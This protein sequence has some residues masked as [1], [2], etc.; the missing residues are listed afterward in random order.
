MLRINSTLIIALIGLI[1]FSSCE[2][3]SNKSKIAE[4]KK[5]NKSLK[6]FELLNSDSTGVKFANTIS[7]DQELVF[8]DFQYQFN[9]GGVAIADFDNDGL[10]DI[11]FTGNEV[12]NKL[13]KNLGGLKFE[14]VTAK[15]GT[16]QSG[17]WCNGVAI[18]D[19]NRDGLMDIYISQGGWL[20][21]TKR[22]NSLFI[23][24]G[25]F[26]FTESAQNFGIADTGYTTQSAFF[27]M[28]LDGDLDLY[29]MNHDNVWSSNSELSKEKYTVRQVTEDRIY[30]NDNGKFIDITLESGLDKEVAG[31]YGLGISVGDINNDNYPDIYISNDYDSPDRLYVNQKDGTFKN[32]TKERTTHIALYSMGNDIADIN[33]DGHLDI[34][35]LDMSAE[36][37]V[38][39]KTQ[40]GA[41][42]P[43]KFYELVRFGFPHQYMYNT[44]QLNNGNGTFSDIA[45]LAGISSTD[46]SWAPISADFDNDGH[47]DIFVSNGY[48]L[49]D[50]DND[51]NN[52]TNQLYGSRK[53]LTKEERRIVFDGTPSTPLANYMYKNNGD[54]TFSKKTYEWNLGEKTFSMGSAFADLDNDGDLDLILNNIEAEAFIYKNNARDKNGNNYL[55]I[56]VDEKSINGEQ[57]K[58][59]LT[60][61]K[62]QQTQ[63]LNPVRGYISSVERTLHFGIGTLD[64]VDKVEIYWNNGKYTVLNNPEINKTHV[65]SNAKSTVAPSEKASNTL[66]AE[67][68]DIKGL[69]FT[70]VEN[71]YDDFENEILLPHRNSQHGPEIEVA[72]VNGDKLDD[73]FICGALGQESALYIQ[74]KNGSFAKK[75]TPAFISEKVK[76]DVGAHFFDY[77][78]DGDV[79]LYVA[80][81]GNEFPENNLAYTD[82]LY[83]NDGKGNFTKTTG[84]IPEIRV[85]GKEVSSADFDGDGDLD[86]FV[87]GR[88]TP[89]KYPF[90]PRSYLLKNENGKFIDVTKETAPSLE[91]PGLVTDSKWLDID[92]DKDLDLVVVGEWMPILVLENKDGNLQKM[93]TAKN[94][95]ENTGWWYS[96][97]S[98]DFDNDGDQDF[99]VGNL[100]LNY[101]YKASSDEPFQVWCHDFDNSG[102]LDIVLG[103]YDHGACFPVR[104]RTCSSQQMPFIKQKFPTFNEFAAATIEDIYGEQL[105][106]AHNLKARNF[107]TSYIENVGNG[108]FKISSLPNQFQF[109][110]VQSMVID[111]FDNDGNLDILG[112]GNLYTAEVETPRNDASIGFLGKG[113]GNGTFSF[114]PYTESGVYMRGDVKDIAAINTTDEKTF[115]L[116]GL[117]DEKIKSI[118]YKK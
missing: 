96:I 39:I 8:Y 118:Q 12:D 67:A 25:N 15:S 98:A 76:E 48:R 99:I 91:A 30:R 17:L 115:F 54:L 60:T 111:D 13:Y 21:T 89:I 87:G 73:V 113:N 34:I 104:G 9:G 53:S 92:N 97:E 84:V 114:M 11:F 31:G 40:M 38:R 71:D 3:E 4:T 65:I 105:S 70:H 10:Q 78:S 33:N 69:D 83:E 74:Q 26:T 55:R 82:R 49:D 5:L 51:Y 2:S 6:M 79:D 42:A 81:G 16:A 20:P 102:T 86:L 72:D 90:A 75:K 36:D 85:S 28:D 19:V 66:F 56:A 109:S 62:G 80:S 46:W 117:N 35:A 110:C 63:V 64:K 18:A 77:D 107:A 23:N 50:R 43:E 1:T 101:K 24:N 41:M 59:V 57:T 58:V 116:V 100:G 61:S 32:E 103:Y 88:L 93:E 27:D 29:V 7:P 37:H 112:G 14:D 47:K 52:S 95:E 44:M 45:Q 22:K 94:L 108:Q 68:E 106:K